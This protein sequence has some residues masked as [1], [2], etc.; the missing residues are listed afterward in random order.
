M[1]AKV[2]YDSM[3]LA[4]L[5][6]ASEVDPFVT[7]LPVG[8]EIPTIDAVGWTKGHRSVDIRPRLVDRSTGQS[9]LLDSGA[10]LSATCRLP[11]DKED[12]S[13]NLLAV[14]GSK[15][16]TYG[17]RKVE[18]KMGRKAYTIDAVICDIKEDILGMDFV[19]KYKLGLEWDEA[20]QTELFLVDKRAQIKSLLKMV[21]VPTDLQRAARVEARLDP[22]NNS[23]NLAPDQGDLNSGLFP[24]EF[25]VACMKWLV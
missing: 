11:E 13:V 5:Q 6:I 15:I 20:T 1:E 16:K 24:T 9:R 3:T 12:H 4:S 22:S 2:Q 18:L 10:Q 17:V 19:D 23:S 21:T 8:V 7:N 14:N 25:Q